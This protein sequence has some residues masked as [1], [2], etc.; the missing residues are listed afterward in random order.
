[1]FV[2]R[3]ACF[4]PMD[5]RIHSKVSQTEHLF[6]FLEVDTWVNFNYYPLYIILLVF[7]ICMP[8]DFGNQP[9]YPLNAMR[10][11]IFLPP[12]L[13]MSLLI[14]FSMVLT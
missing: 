2:Y 12:M 10:I 9:L 5:G 4:V 8:I 7:L 14:C 13:C 3:Y 1:M 11:C 6:N